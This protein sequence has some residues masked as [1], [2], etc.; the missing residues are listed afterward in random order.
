MKRKGLL[1]VLIV[2]ITGFLFG[3]DSVIISGINLPLKQLWHTSDWFHGT[4]IISMVLWGSVTGSLLG[5]YPTEKLGRKKTLILV[6]GLFVASALGTALAVNPYMFSFFRFVGGLGAGIGSIAAPTYI[7]EVAD[8]RHRGRMGMLFQLNLVL[9]ILLAFLSNYFFAISFGAG[10]WRWMLGI[11]VVPYSLFTLLLFSISESPRW[12]IL[13]KGDTATA[14]RVLD[15]ISTREEADRLL[16]AI[17]MEEPSR[18]HAE[19]LFSRKYT[20]VL[21]LSFLMSFFN[22]FSGISFILFYAPE[23]LAKAGSGMAQ[24]LLS[25]V[26]IGVVNVVFTLV[27]IYL[28]D[29]IGRRR[30]MYVG[31]LGYIISLTMVAYGFYI[32]APAVF[33]LVFMLLFITSHAVGQ[34]AVIFVYMS[35]IFPTA[36]R[37]YGQAWGMG[38]LNGLAALI[39]LLGAILIN[40]FQ[41][42]MIF[43][44]FAFLMVLQLLFTAFI[45][46]ETKGV[47]LEELEETLSV[48]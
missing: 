48:K 42:W 5:G 19:R 22:Q 6:G 39:T 25:S 26:A 17:H 14:L 40:A 24:S 3:F 31:S 10:N 21:V 9:G 38:V 13:R 33:M 16:H 41:S 34:G 36:V 44:G 27:G 18:V 15:R 11:M 32:G 12:L 4:F 45:M 8:P 37:A 46:P 20:R 35:E 43:G 29:R 2:S 23:V 47:S 28:I 7:S 30:L 1:C